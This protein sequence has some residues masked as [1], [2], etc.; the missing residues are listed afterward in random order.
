MLKNILKHVIR[1]SK[2]KTSLAK[3]R[4]A[5][6]MNNYSFKKNFSV[7]TVSGMFLGIKSELSKA[8][9]K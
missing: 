8:R 4:Y 3:Y 7:G 6:F 1:K 5:Q 2:K 9:K